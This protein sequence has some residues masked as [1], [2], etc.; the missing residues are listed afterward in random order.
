MSS[1][2]EDIFGKSFDVKAPS[3]NNNYKLLLKHHNNL[4]K[5][6]NELSDELNKIKKY[7]IYNEVAR[8]NPYNI[9]IKK[10]QQ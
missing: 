5:K 6:V 1:T 4:V 10:S 2:L 8:K 7:I 3:E 9:N